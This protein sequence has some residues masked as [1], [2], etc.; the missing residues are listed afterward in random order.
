M[1]SDGDLTAPSSDSSAPDSSPAGQSDPFDLYHPFGAPS[2]V[3]N[4]CGGS[5]SDEDFA[6]GIPEFSDMP[7]QLLDGGW[8]ESELCGISAGFSGDGGDEGGT[9][10]PGDGKIP[11]L[12]QTLKGIAGKGKSLRRVQFVPAARHRDPDE[13]GCD[14]CLAGFD[15][16]FSLAASADSGFKDSADCLEFADLLDMAYPPGEEEESGGGDRDPK[17]GSGGCSDRGILGCG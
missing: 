5:S 14:P 7:F 4:F 10:K 6:A 16:A 8:T 2:S 12:D 17:P 15:P 1:H 3:G 13:N 11:D 9:G